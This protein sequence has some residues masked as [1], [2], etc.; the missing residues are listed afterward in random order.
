LNAEQR[1]IW[2]AHFA[3]RIAEFNA[4]K[5]TG[6]ALVEW[7][8]QHYM[9]DYLAT[10]ASVD[11]SVGRLLDYL[12]ETGL[13]KNTLVVY[14]SDQGFFLGEHG[15]F[16][17]RWIF[18][19]SLRTP[20]VMEW[21]GVIK[22]G[23]VNTDMVSNLDYAETFLDAAGIPVP[24]EMQ[25]RSMMPILRGQTPADWRQEFYYHY[26]EHPAVHN[27]ARHYGIVTDRYKLV[28]FYEPE[29]NYW[30]LFDLKNDP[31]ELKS[32]YGDPKYAP[33][34]KQLHA[35]LDKLRAQYKEPA[36]DP[37]E[38]MISLPKPKTTKAGA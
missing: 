2:D 3:S 17:K 21:P 13:D 7:K 18:E 26:Y 38:S 20:L 12:K 37:P 24:A 33:V 19:Q 8:Y 25:G 4:S 5:L 34:R 32:V 10:I 15:W 30:E 11:E 1:K 36:Q 29:F 9:R 16:D 28:Y 35:D 6:K 27:V 22:P 14:S 23:S 31:M